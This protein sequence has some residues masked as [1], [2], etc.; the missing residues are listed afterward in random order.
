VGMAN[1][2]AELKTFI[3]TTSIPFVA[4]LK[5]LGSIST[6]HELALGMMGM[7]GMKAANHAVQ[8]SDLLICIGARFDDRATGRLNGFAP[9]AKVIHLDV[10]AAE[11]G[12]LRHAEAP[13]AGN[14]R[15]SLNA[16]EKIASWPATWAS[17]RCG[18]RSIFISPIRRST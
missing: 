6:K 2:L 5:G 1:A 10:D 4:T 9:H 16:P 17:T 18:S 14:L 3:E 15:D 11:I 13:V 7:H 8:E 12:K